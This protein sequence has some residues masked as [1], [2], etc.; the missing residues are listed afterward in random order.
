MTAAPMSLLGSV[1]P[2]LLPAPCPPAPQ[3]HSLSPLNHHGSLPYYRYLLLSLPREL[4]I[5]QAWPM[6]S[7][8]FLL[9]W[10]LNLASMGWSIT[11]R[12]HC[13]LA[14]RH[15]SA[16]WHICDPSWA[17]RS[18]CQS[19]NSPNCILSGT[20]VPSHMV[21]S[22]VCLLVNKP[23]WFGFASVFS[24]CILTVFVEC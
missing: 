1:P 17:G 7:S 4:C 24:P 3:K 15:K 12:Q 5:G 14:G 11:V 13:L 9:L 19:R 23:H 16:L 21:P 6:W 20:S 2:A 22:Y 8:F 18:L 10:R